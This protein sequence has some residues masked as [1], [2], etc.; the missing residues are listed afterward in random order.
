[1]RLTL[2]ILLMSC[3]FTTVSAEASVL[4]SQTFAFVRL[5]NSTN[6]PNATTGEAQLGVEVSEVED[7]AN[8]VDFRF[9]NIGPKASSICDIYFDDG[10]LLGIS[11]IFN[12]TG[13]SFSEGATPPSLPGGNSIDFN[14]SPGTFFTADSNPE[15]QP[16]GVNPNESVT[17]RFNLIDS[18]TYSSIISA[19]LLAQQDPLHDQT[20]GLRIGIH[21]Q[22]FE[23]GGSE[24]F[25]NS[26]GEGPSEGSGGGGVPEP[27]TLAIW[28][29]GLGIAGL[30]KL[31]R[32]KLA[33]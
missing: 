20:G 26:G 27:A 22:G 12:S 33:A 17:I 18:Q 32:N 16:N 9:Y 6:G 10:T 25:V 4:Q 19:I 5:P 2:I 13:V 8:Q 7:E 28:G 24:S 11:D 29:L 31:R 15:V 30:V 3:I 21:V 1:M 14:G 23:N